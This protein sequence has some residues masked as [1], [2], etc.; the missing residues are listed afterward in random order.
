MMTNTISTGKDG[1][2]TCEG[3]EVRREFTRGAVR[4][5]AVAT[6]LA[7]LWVLMEWVTS[8]LGSV[9]LA[10][11]AKQKS[12]D[13]LTLTVLFGKT[14]EAEDAALELAG[15]ADASRK[16]FE[17]FLLGFRRDNIPVSCMC[18]GGVRDWGERHKNELSYLEEDANSCVVDCNFVARVCLRGSNTRDLDL[19]AALRVGS[20][21]HP[22]E[23]KLFFAR[24]VD[25]ART[26]WDKLFLRGIES[27]LLLGRRCMAKGL[28]QGLP[29]AQ[30]EEMI[31]KATGL[32]VIWYPK[33]LQPTKK[34]EVMKDVPEGGDGTVGVYELVASLVAAGAY[35]RPDVDATTSM[36]ILTRR[37]IFIIGLPAA[38]KDKGAKRN[39][40]STQQQR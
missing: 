32:P 39:A 18:L 36:V 1:A 22:V 12:L 16:W 26:P 19:N 4:L 15:R 28:A 3:A 24:D 21:L 33:M 7:C 37:A 13:E 29:A 8:P 10:G 35:E 25:E 17:V 20:F 34:I 6:A 2:V 40:T 14:K 27:E 23:G 11:E 38:E 5:L 31:E 9:G 30:A